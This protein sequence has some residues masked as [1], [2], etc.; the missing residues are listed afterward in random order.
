MKKIS[1]LF[2]SLFVLASCSKDDDND[3]SAAKSDAKAITAFTFAAADNDALSEDV[4]AAIDEDK[5]T[6]TAEVPFSTDV[7]A[8][9]PTIAVSEKATV[10]PENKVAKDFTETVEYTVTAEDGSEAKYAVTV[11]VAKSDAKQIMTFSFLAKDNE[12]LS[13]DIEGEVDESN[14]T[15]KVEVPFG[16]KTSELV[17]TI[18]TSL[19]STVSPDNGAVKDFSE[20]IEYTVT[21]EDASTTKYTITVV[22]KAPTD[23]QV[24]IELYN[25]NPDNTLDWDLDDEDMS[26]WDG[27]YSTDNIEV[28]SLIFFEK[29]LTALNPVIGKLS[30]LLKLNLDGNDITELP[31]EIGELSKLKDLSFAENLITDIPTGLWKLTQ[32][33]SLSMGDNFLTVLDADIGKLENLKSLLLSGNQFTNLPDEIGNLLNLKFLSIFN[34]KLENV[35]STIGNLNKL[36]VLY[37][38]GNQLVNIPSEIGKLTSLTTLFVE[39]NKLNSLPVEI[40]NL[41][42]LGDLRLGGNLFTSL[43]TE[44]GALINLGV[45]LANKNLLTTVPASIGNLTKL[46]TLLLQENQLTLIP[47]EIC[48]L[49]IPNFRIDTAAECEQ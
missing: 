21:A 31:N 32:L 44:I 33:E 19:G 15:V 47:K 43:P 20:V 41:Q 8:L 6:I 5:K 14:L 7:T 10:S 27:V 24:L 42:N 49:N 28:D 2:L 9:E 11:A 39:R 35:P 1:I 48:D 12:S 29:N 34:G 23:R 46:R 45:L 17:P 22:I 26:N 25:A 3:N 30:N 36:E 38:T 18:V 40:E 16:T 37:L 4:K 13:E